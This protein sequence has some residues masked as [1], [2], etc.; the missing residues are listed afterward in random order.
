MSKKHHKHEQRPTVTGGKTAP[1]PDPEVAPPLEKRATEL[2]LMI[3]E[4]PNGVII[5]DWQAT[6]KGSDIIIPMRPS[7][8][9]GQL[10]AAIFLLE[11]DSYKAALE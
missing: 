3:T 10:H 11:R 6:L 5:L 8:V 2:R 4:R 7:H 9:I 1:A